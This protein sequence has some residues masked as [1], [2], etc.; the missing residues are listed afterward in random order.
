MALSDIAG[1]YAYAWGTIQAQSSQRASTAEV[2][3]AVKQIAEDLGMDTPPGMFRAVNEMRS[4]A[5]QMR[6]AGQAFNRASPEARLT[7]SL[8]P[9]DINARALADRNI[10]PEYLARFEMTHR[11]A[12]GELVTITRSMRDTWQPGLTVGDVTS[13]VAEVALGLANDYGIDL[14]STSIIGIVAV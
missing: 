3:A 4:L 11:T 2:F 14:Q 13:T 7:A 10:F 8:A 1:K 9:P 12:E 5:V 6:N